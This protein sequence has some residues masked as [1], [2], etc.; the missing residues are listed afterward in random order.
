VLRQVAQGVLIHESEFL[1]SNAV[2]VCLAC[3]HGSSRASPEEA[4][5]T[6]RPAT[7]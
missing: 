3:T 2:V 6:G 4:S 1:H 7:R 5:A